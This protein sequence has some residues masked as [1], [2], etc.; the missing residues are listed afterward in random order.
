MN[1]F[2]RKPQIDPSIPDFEN[3]KEVFEEVADIFKHMQKR[4][5]YEWSLKGN[6]ALKKF[7]KKNNSWLPELEFK[8]ASGMSS[9]LW[10]NIRFQLIDQEIPGSYTHSKIMDIFRSTCNYLEELSDEYSGSKSER[11]EFAESLT[12]GLY[13]IL[14]RE[15]EYLAQPYIFRLCAVWVHFTLIE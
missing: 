2:R 12:H 8:V 14:Q 6:K 13:L 3:S 15:A 4:L 7:I 11:E 10:D 1:F 5:P 9:D